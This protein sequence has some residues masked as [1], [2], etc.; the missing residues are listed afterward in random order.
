MLARMGNFR[1]GDQRHGNLVESLGKGAGQFDA[2]FER[3]THNK[4]EKIFRPSFDSEDVTN[5]KDLLTQ[6]DDQLQKIDKDMLHKK[7]LYNKYA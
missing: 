1:E 4:H 5:A 6:L 3:A 7:L 2:R